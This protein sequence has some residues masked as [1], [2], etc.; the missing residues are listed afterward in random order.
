LLLDEATS[1]LDNESESAIQKT[2]ESITHTMTIVVIAH[3]LTT[4]R[5]ADLIHVIEDGRLVETGTYNELI[6]AKG[7]FSVLHE[8]QFA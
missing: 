6:D 2:L 5:N 4:V 3:R 1:S 7:R 8:A